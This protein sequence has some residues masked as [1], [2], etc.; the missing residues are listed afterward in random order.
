[1]E[2]GTAEPPMATRSR[3]ST[4]L[5]ALV[6]VV[7]QHGEHRGHAQREGDPLALDQLLQ[8]LAVHLRAGEHQA[9]AAER[10]PR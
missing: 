3:L 4:V 6:Q 8:A 1:M 2:R 9:R 5:A 7:D 10:Q